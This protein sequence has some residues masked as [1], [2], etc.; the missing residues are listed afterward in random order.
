MGWMSLFVAF[1]YR[2]PNVFTSF[3]QFASAPQPDCTWR[4]SV[5]GCAGARGK[6]LS[7]CAPMLSDEAREYN[8]P[9]QLFGGCLGRKYFAHPTIPTR[10]VVACYDASPP[11]HIGSVPEKP[12][13]THQT[14]SRKNRAIRQGSSPCPL[15]DYTCALLSHP[16]RETEDRAERKRKGHE[17]GT[18]PQRP[19]H[20]G[21]RSN[22][23]VGTLGGH[24][25]GPVGN[26]CGGC[27]SHL[28]PERFVSEEPL[29]RCP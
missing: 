2:F 15:P 6:L 10:T 17:R 3:V 8:F 28:G 4:C 22:R 19:L 23:L 25:N 5:I 16:Q 12:A 9:K 13:E 29:Q 20:G 27:H 26:A 24:R 1:A 18:W 7:T 11:T 14:S 21:L